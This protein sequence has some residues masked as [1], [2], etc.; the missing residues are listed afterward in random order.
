MGFGANN[1]FA[2]P[3]QGVTGRIGEGMNV[4]DDHGYLLSAIKK[5]PAGKLARRKHTIWLC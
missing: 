4:V 1:V 3:S 2:R 5:L